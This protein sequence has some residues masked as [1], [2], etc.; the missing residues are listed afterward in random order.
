MSD[1]RSA[2]VD[3]FVVTGRDAPEWPAPHP[4]RPP[5]EQEY[6]RCL[7]PARYAIVGARLR[8]WS[9][10]LV[11]R[12]GV[13]VESPALREVDLGGL[14]A[15]ADLVER[16]QV[17]RPR[18]PG[19]LP[20]MLATWSMQGVP[21][22]VLA[23]G[24]GDPP[25]WVERQPDCGCDACDSGSADLL[26]VLDETIET[27]VTGHFLHITTRT[28]RMWRVLGRHR[29]VGDVDLQGLQDPDRL[30]PGAVVLRGRA[31]S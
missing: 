29:G 17:W 13:A 24:V 25:Q 3:R 6:S 11:R 31:W 19:E 5:L 23:I 30:P 18:G 22:A 28:G 1:L 4:E 10:V 2:V 14:D 15:A 16:F 26:A 20:L 21:D 9:D 27:V 8:A 12:F 7:D